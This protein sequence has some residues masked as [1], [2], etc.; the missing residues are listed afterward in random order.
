[1]E[2]CGIPQKF[3]KKVLWITLEQKTQSHPEYLSL[4]AGE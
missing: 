1:M 3:H 4:S 2:K